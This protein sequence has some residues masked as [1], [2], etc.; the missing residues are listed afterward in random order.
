MTVFAGRIDPE[1]DIKGRE[2]IVNTRSLTGD[3]AAERGLQDGAQQTGNG[4]TDN[5]SAPVSGVQTATVAGAGFTASMVG[6]FVTI[7]SM[8]NGVNNGTFL[9]TAQA[10]TTIS[11]VNA[12]GV[13]EANIVATFD[14]YAPY[15]LADNVDFNA[16]DRKNIK[17]TA[18]HYT[19]VPTYVRPSAIGTNVDANLTNI[20]GNTL[21]AK[22]EVTDV[23][24]AGIK[25]RPSI[26]DGDGN[27]LVSDETFTTTNYHFIA[28]DLDSFVTITDGTSTGAA[29]TY[30]IK[31]VTDGKTLELDGF[32]PTGAGTCTWVLEG[33]LK[34]Y[35]SSRSY[36]DAVDR[37]GIPIADSGAEDETVYEAT[38]ADV[39]D[40]VTGGRPVEEDGDQ[41]YGRTFGD[42]K[43]PNNT[44]TNEGTRAFVQLKT[45]VNSGAAADSLLE[46]I[47]GRSG[48]AASLP[49]GN[50]TVNGLTG[51]TAQDIGRYL[52]IWNL[53]ADEADHRL[54]TGYNSATSVDLAGANFTADA[55][56]AIEWQVSRHPGTWDFYTGDRYRK[57]EL[58]ETAGRTTLIGGIVADA[59]LTQDI[60]EIRE[61]IGAADGDTTP[62]LT[63]T[64]ADYIWSD[65]PN[66]ADTS[67][68]ECLN[69][70]NEQV[71]DRQYT[72]VVLTDGAT[73]TAN[74]QELA[75]AISGSSITRVIERLT[76]DVAKNTAHT[77]PG[78]NTYTLDGTDNGANMFVVW[79]KQWRDPGPNTV[80]SNDY[81]E[82]STTQITPYEKIADGDSINYLILQ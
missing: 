42:E 44:A 50:T 17:G 46:P 34:G 56:G 51:M 43:D 14:V 9:V 63:N 24:Q 2:S 78:G 79:R 64:G 21:D 52:T 30:R 25:L 12:A 69:E 60:A 13:V 39:I 61:F 3:E 33:D 22:A 1:L 59:E 74:L 8:V 15:S 70:I 20:A 45:G 38:F 27:C 55:S 29:G 32:A 40:P 19:A 6:K 47:S 7:A 73:I 5:V 71:G 37:R 23:K 72:G 35:L 28:G 57:D 68:E 31:A 26:A 4:T 11:Y 10:G 65:L 48:S 62:A 16:T 53:A 76:A 41:I 58:S 81:E 66:P 49:G 80:T 82:T 18:Q 75:N 67:V 54:I 77:L 36:A